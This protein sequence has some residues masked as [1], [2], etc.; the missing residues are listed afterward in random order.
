VVATYNI[1]IYQ[2]GELESVLRAIGGRDINLRILMEIKVTGEIYTQTLSGY[3]IF[4]SNAP[5]AHQ[6]GITLF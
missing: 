4:V 1:L 6:G 2:N 5:S 3:S